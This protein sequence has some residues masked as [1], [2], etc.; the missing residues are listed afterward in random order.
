MALQ[1]IKVPLELT[2]GIDT[3]IDEFNNVSFKNIENFRF[4]KPGALNK[5]PG[6]TIYNTNLLTLNASM[7]TITDGRA[8]YSLNNQLLLNTSKQSLTYDEV[9]GKWISKN[10]KNVNTATYTSSAQSSSITYVQTSEVEVFDRIANSTEPDFYVNSEYIV[11]TVSDPSAS[12]VKI[13][14]STIDNK[15]KILDSYIPDLGTS[16]KLSETYT[17]R[18]A[19]IYQS[20]LYVCAFLNNATNLLIYIYDLTTPNVLPTTSSQNFDDFKVC[21]LDTS[22][23]VVYVVGASSTTLRV[24]S[25]TISTSTFTSVNTTISQTITPKYIDMLS[26]V[27]KVTGPTAGNDN[28]TVSVSKSTLTTTT[29]LLNVGT[30][31]LS[32]CTDGTNVYYN[33]NGTLTA[34]DATD[35]TNILGGSYTLG[36]SY[37]GAD[38]S[39]GKSVYNN[40]Y[41]YYNIKVGEIIY[42]NANYLTNFINSTLLT[43]KINIS[44]VGTT[45]IDPELIGQSGYFNSIGLDEH[46]KMFFVDNAIYTGNV[47]LKEFFDIK[48]I[49]TNITTQ[50]NSW[51]IVKHEILEEKTQETYT[52][53]YLIIPSSVPKMFDGENIVEAGFT[54][55]P[56]LVNGSLGGSIGS[57]ITIAQGVYGFAT[58]FA[59]YDNL[60]NIHRSAPC[61]FTWNNSSPTYTD[62]GFTLRGLKAT[63][64]KNVFIEIYTT[65]TDGEIYYK[66]PQNYSSSGGGITLNW[67]QIGVS[68][69]EILYTNGGVLENDMPMYGIGSA[70]FKN[71]VFIV[72]KD[73][74][75]YSNN[76]ES[77]QPI[78]FNRDS[79]IVPSTEGGELLAAYGMDNVLVVFEQD[80]ISILSGNGP[81]NLGQQSDYQP[82]QKIPSNVGL[83]DL[84]SVVRTPD[85]IMFKSNKGIYLLN[86]GL[87][88]SYIGTAV[89]QYN[90]ETILAATLLVDKNEVRFL[91][92]SRILIYDLDT[93]LW[94][95]D[96]NINA[97]PV[98]G[99]VHAG[100]YHYLT[101][102]GYVY[103]NDPTVFK[104]N[105]YYYNGKLE[106]NWITVSGISNSGGIARGQQGY[107]RLYS[108][109]I[110]GKHKS[111]HKL[112][113]Q[114]AYN[115][116]E[117][118]LYDVEA[119]TIPG[120]VY[121]QE[122]R[123]NIQKCQAFKLI[124]EDTTQSGTGESFILSSIIME[125]GVKSTLEKTTG[126]SNRFSTS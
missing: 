18:I 41:I 117:S 90:N 14:I 75:N 38:S 4:N 28:Y 89:E 52:D 99:V 104:N 113:V 54:C 116:D 78:T 94:A 40:G 77:G 88:V 100:N 98:D 22:A 50:I 97:T 33:V 61:Y 29:S 45:P 114:I 5:A 30:G 118:E 12:G 110:L 106:T 56:N 35:S 103:K 67:N 46:N 37:R 26:S 86:R 19:G 7:P 20:K 16:G 108:I 121:Q 49:P 47:Q 95:I 66:V 59:W 76:I 122:I 39:I 36:S 65:E 27:F 93:K 51:H 124:I 57:G 126:D 82:L 84:N 74:I 102:S 120:A 44:L 92:A 62:V 8:I 87:Y 96:T 23:G 111:A 109:Y 79:T 17:I 72:N 21:D 69:N 83:K 80:G 63:A 10:F 107:Q 32:T 71:R 123:P 81:N 9:Y 11:S 125:V 2:T 6:Y 31:T 64:K 34:T 43:F 101:T 91:T 3:K 1:K 112:K 70:N 68:S 58:V 73:K 119:T 60:G 53:N 25:Y 48:D 115:Y 85:G 24:G 105:D 42:A 13:S 15:T 55:T